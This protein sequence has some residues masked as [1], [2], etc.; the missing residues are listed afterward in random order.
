LE[1]IHRVK[2]VVRLSKA[3]NASWHRKHHNYASISLTF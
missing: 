3:V 2:E 1:Y